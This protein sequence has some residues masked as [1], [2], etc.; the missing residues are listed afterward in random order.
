[1]DKDFS[2][3]FSDEKQFMMLKARQVGKS[4]INTLMEW[5]SLHSKYERVSL[6]KKRIKSIFNIQ[7]MKIKRFNE[8]LDVFLIDPINFNNS[9]GVKKTIYPSVMVN[10]S[11]TNTKTKEDI[12]KEMYNLMFNQGF[13]TPPKFIDMNTGDIIDDRLRYTIT[14]I[15]WVFFVE[16]KNL[17][18]AKEIADKF[19]VEFYKNK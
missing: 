16:E 18:K 19:G 4:C 10:F 13:S 2:Q 17:S 11:K 6:R 7:F 9:K 12:R 3:L 1:M 5:H 14:G 15:R 8:D